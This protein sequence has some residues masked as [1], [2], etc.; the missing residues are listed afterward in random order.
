MGEEL[1]LRADG[2]GAITSCSAMTGEEQ[3]AVNWAH[4]GPGR[5]ELTLLFPGQEGED[6][7]TSEVVVQYHATQIRNEA[8]GLTAVLCDVDGESFGPLSG[9]LALVS[10]IE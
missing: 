4:R 8:G 6:H 10:K 7:F 9:R 5:V 1:I 3:V 2:T